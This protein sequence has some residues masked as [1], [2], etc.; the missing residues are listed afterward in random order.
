MTW[1]IDIVLALKRISEIYLSKRK[2]QIERYKEKNWLQQFKNEDKFLYNL[3]DDINIYLYKNSILSKLIFSGF[4]DNEISF[5]LRYLKF[6]DIFIDIGSNIGLYALY[7]AKLI[8][9]NGKVIAFEPTP[10]TYKRLQENIQLNDFE[11]II[12]PQNIGLSDK[13][14]TMK[15]NSFANGYDAWNTFATP[16][17]RFNGEQIDVSVDTL[18]NSLEKTKLPIGGIALIKIDVE[19][20]ET[21]VLKGAKKL[22]ST[23]DSPVLL[24]E[25]TE[26][27]AFAA[28]S[29]CYELYDLIRS[30]GYKWYTYNKETNELYPEPKRIHYP[31]NNLIAIKDINKAI[32]RISS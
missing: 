23:E 30:F 17:E 18:D 8:G 15:L 4:E 2:R 16:S 13:E 20:W 31:Y 6:S 28:G 10:E 32:A 27:Y 14:G 22:L 25:F 5:L 19:G 26:E 3:T 21:Y 7:A 11:K 29:N 12:V 9:R 1:D 24:V